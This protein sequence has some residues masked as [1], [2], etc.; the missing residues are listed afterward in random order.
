MHRNNTDRLPSFV[1][2]V[3]KEMKRH[4]EPAG[5]P[6]PGVLSRILL[7]I[8]QAHMFVAPFCL[9]TKVIL[10]FLFFQIKLILFVF[11]CLFFRFI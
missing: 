6:K 3:I 7:P 11:V 5:K 1:A 9:P 10:P 2:N 8:L 4:D